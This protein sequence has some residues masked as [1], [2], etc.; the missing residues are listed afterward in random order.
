[1]LMLGLFTVINLR[2]ITRQQ[3]LAYKQRYC[4]TISVCMSVC[5]VVVL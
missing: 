5:H 1:M 4:F 2:V 3:V